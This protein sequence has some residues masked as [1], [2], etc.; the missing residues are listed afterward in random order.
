MNMT[1]LSIQIA[2]KND[3]KSSKWRRAHCTNDQTGKKRCVQCAQAH[4]L[5][6]K[7]ALCTGIYIVF[8]LNL[9]FWGPLAMVF[10]ID[11]IANLQLQS[12]P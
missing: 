7:I 12:Q 9:H 11:K 1:M 8:E 2:N 6:R 4:G 3:E 5:F 10:G